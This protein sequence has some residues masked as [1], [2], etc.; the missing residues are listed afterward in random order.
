[1][2]LLTAIAAAAYA[3]Q[4]QQVLAS[5]DELDSGTKLNFSS[6]SPHIFGSVF[7]LL[8]QWPNTFFPNG[9]T[10]VPCEIPKGINLYHG[11]VGTSMPPSPEWFAFDVEMSYAIAG[12][13][14]T[15]H[16][17]TYRTTKPVKCLYF[18]GASASLFGDGQLD[19]QMVFIHNNSANVPDDPA[20]GCRPPRGS[21]PSD[22]GQ[23]GTYPSYNGSF[24]YR[25][26]P[27]KS[28]YDR[29][30]GLCKF[31]KDEGLGG[32]GWGYE[33]IVRMNA[34]FEMI[35]CDFE[36]PS[37][38]LISHISVGAPTLDGRENDRR[39]WMPRESTALALRSFQ[40]SEPED[41]EVPTKPPR[42][43]AIPTRPE[44][45]DAFMQ[46]GLYNWFSAATRRYGFVGGLSGGGE[47]RVKLDTC[48]IFSLY[49]PALTDQETARIDCDTQTLNLS[50]NGGW[51]RPD[52]QDRKAAIQALTRRRRPHRA[53][54]V[55]TADGLFM[56]TAM[57]ERM[58]SAL[59]AKPCSGI[60]WHE[61]TKEIILAYSGGLL[62]LSKL[63]SFKP[64]Q[65]TELR[66]RLADV[67]AITH[68]L[69]MPF[70][71]YPKSASRDALSDEYSLESANA[72][73]ALV[74]CSRQYT[75]D[76]RDI[77]SDSERVTYNAISEVLATICDGILPVFLGVELSWLES[78]NNITDPRPSPDVQHEVQ[79]QFQAWLQQI[80][81]L[82][83]WLG[84]IDQWTACE[85][86]C[87]LGEVCYIPMWP[88]MGLRRGF[89]RP[90][91]GTDHTYGRH[92]NMGGFMDE[93]EQFLWEPKC[94]DARHFPPESEE[95]M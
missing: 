47:T 40:T 71:E 13:E 52:A 64:I 36:S 94:V 95:E 15:S 90:R 88:A 19:S 49:D 89:G 73:E 21:Q 59:E 10:I 63:L 33:G 37:A 72:Q 22:P 31:I 16:M 27:L 70:Y 20:F 2:Q 62:D 58:R 87:G 61:V 32:P 11:R 17:L 30:D 75:L 4:F 56:R 74:R 41:P 38:R 51:H 66:T 28:E 83:A 39:R 3:Q 8:Q 77:L 14:Q 67:R 44:F 53:A 34:A 82:M 24:P 57:E 25:C 45:S 92:R 68:G 23:N 29:A 48:R 81:E 50:T 43:P 93:I 9:H 1:M 46:I 65:R 42:K 54:N 78:F 5:S 55:S 79:R 18:D 86:G 69:Y 84:W 7:G 85:P 60:D 76:D 26:N 12:W 35:W 91:N 80:E 6:P